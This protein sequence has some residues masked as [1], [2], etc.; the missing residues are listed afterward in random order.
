MADKKYFLATTALDEFWDTDKPLLFLGEWCLRYDRRSFREPF[1]GHLIESP[2]QNAESVSEAYYAVSAVYERILPHLAEALNEMHG[3][4][5]GLRYWRIIIGPWLYTYLC[6]MHDRYAHICSALKQ[7]PS[8][9]TTVLSEE[10]FVVPSDTLEFNCR[11]LDDAFNLQIFTK[12]LRSLGKDFPCKDLHLDQSSLFS[13]LTGGSWRQRA[14]NGLTILYGRLAFAFCPP[15]VV[16][17]DSYFPRKKESQLFLRLRGRALPIRGLNNKRMPHSYDGKMREALRRV[18]LGEDAFSKCLSDMLY[19]DIPHCFVEDFKATCD[20][21]EC[22]YPASPKAIFSANGWYYD[23]AFKCWAAASAEKGSLLLGTPH[24]GSYGARLY[25]YALNHETAITD[26]YYSWGWEKKDCAAEVIPMPA[27]KLMGV[28]R[29]SASNLKDGILWAATSAPRYLVQFPHVPAMYCGYIQWNQ[30]FTRALP[31]A[32]LPEIRLRAHYQDCGWGLIP[33][34]KE[35][36]PQLRLDTWEV[37]FLESMSRCRLYVC[38]HLSTTFAEALAANQPTILFWNPETNVLRPEAIPYFD[39][40]RDSG[41]LFDSPEAAADAVANAYSD[42]ESWWNDPERQ[43]AVREFCDRHART[44]PDAID[45][46]DA[47]FRRVFS[48]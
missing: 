48:D 43:R 25:S 38:D 44:S 40:L 29:I 23:E 1:G 45:L 35:S 9:T 2:F 42:V 30:R 6:V 20:M 39:L 7:F 11:L 4:G 41:I 10:S 16:F 14:F 5:H 3:R 28:E 37:P 47:E 46:W 34:L 21:G 8:L 15:S 32:L 24:G 27:P 31:E 17:K 13:S 33:R 26:Y 36:V 22:T 12:I 18:P 19:S